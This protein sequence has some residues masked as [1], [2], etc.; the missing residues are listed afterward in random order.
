MSR[1]R[2]GQG[3]GETKV[4]QVRVNKKAF[5]NTANGCQ[6]ADEIDVP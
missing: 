4:I 5:R 2:K 6:V 1:W 3:G